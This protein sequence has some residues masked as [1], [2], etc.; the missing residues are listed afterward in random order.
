MLWWWIKVSSVLF[1]LLLWSILVMD[2]YAGISMELSQ[3]SLTLLHELEQRSAG[4]LKHKHEL[5]VLI[6]IAHHH[7]MLAVLD[8]LSFFAKFAHKTFG[9][10]NRIGKDAEG[11]ERLSQEFGRS[12]EKSR[13]FLQVLLQPASGDIKSEFE[14][15]FLAMSPHAFQNLLALLHD[16][17]W[18]KNYLID[19]RFR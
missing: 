15:E 1:L 14:S 17:G 12:L 5:G 7:H 3:T 19:T 13:G 11:Y 6:E 10:M 9:I 4:N 8:E 18:Y 2:H 16:V